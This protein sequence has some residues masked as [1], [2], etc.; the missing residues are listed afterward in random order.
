MYCERFR[1]SE[2]FGD[3]ISLGWS[4]ATSVLLSS[5][6]VG[7]WGRGRGRQPL[8]DLELVSQFIALHKACPLFY[9]ALVSPETLPA[10]W[11]Q[12][13]SFLYM[14]PS[15]STVTHYVPLP[16]YFS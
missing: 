16:Y 2:G 4:V 14:S 7:K 1:L 9:Q 5:Y 12:I 8:M 10:L 15:V 3:V 13:C 6:S 11:V